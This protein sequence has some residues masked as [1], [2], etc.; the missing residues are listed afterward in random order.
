MVEQHFRKVKVASST[1]ASGSNGIND[2]LAFACPVRLCGAKSLVKM[3][4]P[5]CPVGSL[6]SY[7]VQVREVAPDVIDN[8]FLNRILISST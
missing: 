8:R 6:L 4:F 7:G 3:G 2:A 5:A 1:L